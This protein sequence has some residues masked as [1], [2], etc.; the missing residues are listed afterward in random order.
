MLHPRYAFRG[1]DARMS[2]LLVLR[3]AEPMLRTC[4]VATME[5]LTQYGVEVVFGIPGVHTLEFCRGLG[6]DSPLRHIRARHEQGAGFMADGYARATGRPGVALVISGPGVTNAATAL[7]QSYADSIPVLLISAEPPRASLGKGFGV[8]HEITEQ[9]AVT[10]PLTAFSATALMPQDV[11]ELIRQAFVLFASERPRPVHISIPTDVLEMPVTEHWQAVASPTRPTADKASIAAAAAMLRQS[12][13]PLLMLGRGAIGASPAA[14]SLAERL[15]AAFM[16]SVAGKGVVSDYH[17][18]SVGA[19][20]GRAR[21]HQLIAH[22]DV[23]LAVG[24]EISE[25][26]TFVERLEI[27]GKLI[28]IDLDSRKLNDL[29]PADI[30]IVA[31][32][33]VL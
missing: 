7:G 33:G 25:T 13:R 19:T 4:G 15:D 6:D 17:P 24:T 21:V 30:G 10:A 26:D 11:P 27:N 16:P 32:A 3:E 12:E 28:R 22:A 9:K 14:T 31:D 29:Y 23:I 1:T 18:L 8:L 2:R 20:G 5:L